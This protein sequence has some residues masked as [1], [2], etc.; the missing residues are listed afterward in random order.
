MGLLWERM[1]LEEGLGVVLQ[2]KL[3]RK[4]LC[5]D[6]ENQL[7]EWMYPGLTGRIMEQYYSLVSGGSVQEAGMWMTSLTQCLRSRV[8]MIGAG[9]M[10]AN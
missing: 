6:E 10:A 2:Q 1:W 5:A 7:L 3:I 8:Q 4:H 9:F